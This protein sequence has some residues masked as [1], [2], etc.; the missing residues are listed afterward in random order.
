MSMCRVVVVLWC[1]W[2]RFGGGVMYV[3]DVMWFSVYVVCVINEV[4]GVCG[5]WD[6]YK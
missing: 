3:V 1:M 2:W 4:R 5:V 6:V